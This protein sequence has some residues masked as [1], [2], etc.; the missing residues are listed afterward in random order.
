MKEILLKKNKIK[1]CTSGCNQK[2]TSDSSATKNHFTKIQT[3]PAKL[4]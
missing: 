3:F 2:A 4:D 1:F